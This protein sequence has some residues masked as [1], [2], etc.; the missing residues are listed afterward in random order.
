M[1]EP[2]KRKTET[3]SGEKQKRKVG[4]SK[5]GKRVERAK[6]EKVGGLRF[7]LEGLVKG[8]GRDEAPPRGRAPV[9]RAKAESGL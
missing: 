3:V 1:S 4:A 2:G 5:S 7:E 8:S 6:A 9:E